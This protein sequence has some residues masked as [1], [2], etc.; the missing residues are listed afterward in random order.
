MAAIKFSKQNI[1]PNPSEVDYWV[2]ITSNPYGGRLKYFN[3]TDWVDLVNVDDSTVD[4][5]GYYTKLQ[6]NQMLSDKASVSSVESKV[7]DDEI[8]DVI[9]NIDIKDIGNDGIQLVLF[10]YDNTNVAVTFPVAS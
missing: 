10:K 6:I 5:N 1:K 4:L 9:K 3:G 8:K 2:D 7:D